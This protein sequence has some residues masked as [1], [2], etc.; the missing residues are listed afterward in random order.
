MGGHRSGPC[1][2]PHLGDDIRLLHG[3]EPEMQH[4]IQLHGE[5]LRG[6]D[7]FA[8]PV[9]PTAG[10]RGSTTTC[11]PAPEPEG[12]DLDRRSESEAVFS[13]NP[14]N[15]VHAYRVERDAGNGRWVRR[16]DNHTST[17]YTDTSLECD[18]TYQ[19][20]VRARGDGHPYS[21]TYGMAS[22][23]E[24]TSVECIRAPPAPGDVETEVTE[25][26]D[27][28]ISWEEVPG[29][30]K[31]EVSHWRGTGSRPISAETIEVYDNWHTVMGLAC[32]ETYSF[33]VRPYGDGTALLEEWGPRARVSQRLDCP[34]AD[35]PTNL[36]V[37]ATTEISAELSWQDVADAEAYRIE[38]RTGT[39]NWIEKAKGHRGTTYTFT[40]ARLRHLLLFRG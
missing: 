39:G 34:K 3:A 35:M 24:R 33:A 4:Y 11:P 38:W 26:G 5:G 8:G 2:C 31:Y 9:G 10:A 21:T 1:L 30:T 15:D 17:S 36:G 22:L 28:R 6:R 7:G 13:W 18:I 27:I 29:T 37:S 19:F 23:S 12:L 20:R 16:A 25:N 14:E 32:N 40:G